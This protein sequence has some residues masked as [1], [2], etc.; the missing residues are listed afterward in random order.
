MT[1]I[2]TR[3]SDLRYASIFLHD[4]ENNVDFTITDSCIRFL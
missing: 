1:R 3:I 4:F 2:D